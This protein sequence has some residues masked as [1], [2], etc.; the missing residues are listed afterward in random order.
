MQPN[1][2]GD[3]W[4]KLTCV[5]SGWDLLR[6]QSWETSGPLAPPHNIPFNYFYNASEE[7]NGNYV[8]PPVVV[9]G[10]VS[11]PLFSFP[12]F[13]LWYYWRSLIYKHIGAYLLSLFF[14]RRVVWLWGLG[15]VNTFL[16]SCV[17]TNLTLKQ[18]LSCSFVYTSYNIF[19]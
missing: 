2:H 6:W 15:I 5:G 12:L 10:V 11:F 19:L 13:F 8:Q 7:A 18:V 9:E 14:F 4:S 16:C 17:P 1:L 3:V